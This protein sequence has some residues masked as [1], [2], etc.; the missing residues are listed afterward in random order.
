MKS[1]FILVCAISVLLGACASTGPEVS[2]AAGSSAPTTGAG[3]ASADNSAVPPL[4]Q[5]IGEELGDADT[6]PMPRT[7]RMV[8]GG[9]DPHEIICKRERQTGSKFTVKTCMTRA[10]MEERAKNDQEIM[11]VYQRKRACTVSRSQG[12]PTGC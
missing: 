4:D 9:K 3:T 5:T 10:E 6:G 11:E 12:I 7:N 2:D 1:R 8:A